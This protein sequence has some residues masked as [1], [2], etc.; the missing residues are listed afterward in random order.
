MLSM[1]LKPE[2]RILTKLMRL[3]LGVGL[4]VCSWAAWAPSSLAAPTTSRIAALEN[5]IDS[6]MIGAGPNDYAVAAWGSAPIYGPEAPGSTTQVF[7][8]VRAA[9]DDAF[10][11]PNQVTASAAGLP[12]L[13]VGE[14]GETV[15]A[16][17][18]PDRKIAVRTRSISRSWSKVQKLV[19]PGRSLTVSALDIDVARDGTA[20]LA[21][22][23]NYGLSTGSTYV[24]VKP[25]RSSRFRL[26]KTVAVSQRSGLFVSVA[27]RTRGRGLVAW[28]QSCRSQTTVA[29]S[30]P[31]RYQHVRIRSQHQN[32]ITYGRTRS[33]RSSKCSHAGLDL[34]LN[35]RGQGVLMINGYLQHYVVRQARMTHRS[36]GK[37]VRVSPPGSL[38]SFASANISRKGMV[39]AVASQVQSGRPAGATSASA[40]VS[41]PVMLRERKES[42]RVIFLDRT[43]AGNSSGAVG[44][45]TE[46]LVAFSIDIYLKRSAQRPFES[47]SVFSNQLASTSLPEASGAV[48]PDGRYLLIWSVPPA[49]GHNGTLFVTERD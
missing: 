23:Q 46:N 8:S 11:A 20:I 3:T 17:V 41:K 22:S 25:P 9:N 27:A 2:I 4:V 16:W 45:A 28:A 26:P 33:V 32:S 1:I 31:T 18:T 34:D 44:F 39:T 35:D 24:A 47:E 38:M 5:G 13:D 49:A 15:L 30:Q 6:P 48:T 19:P 43:F 12:T 29:R 7:T 36:F 42:T 14:A 40:P 10:G 37:A 21:W